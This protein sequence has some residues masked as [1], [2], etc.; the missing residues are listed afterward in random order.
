MELNQFL[1]KNGS[2]ILTCAGAVG[3]VTT[4]VLSVKATPKALQKLEEAKE[5]KKEDLT[6]LEKVK[7]VGPS[8]IPAVLSGVGTLACIFGANTLSRRQQAALSS[9]YALVDASFKEYK[10]KLKELYGEETH[11]KI[12][13]AIAVEKADEMYV[14]SGY[15]CGTCDLGGEG[16]NPAIFYD[17]HSGRYFSATIEQVIT[18]EY[19]LNRNYILRGYAYLNEFYEFL[20]IDETDY[21]SVLGWTPTDDGEYWIEFN[22]RKEYFEGGMEYY[23]IE[24]PF[25][26]SYDFLEYE[27][28]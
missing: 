13:D 17:E 14:R 16:S 24:M 28:Y 22:H 20:G 18:A 9:A 23:I 8:Y 2:T 27:Y 1:R 26:P 6:T 3:V 11:N 5:E 10:T 19:H 7:A 12:V 21:G 25:E 4:A 15:M